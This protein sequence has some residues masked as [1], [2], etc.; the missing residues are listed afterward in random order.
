MLA[1]AR[2]ALPRP[3]LV[4]ARRADEGRDARRGRARRARG[5]RAAPRARRRASSP[6]TTTATSSSA[7]ASP[8]RD[9][10]VV[11]E[12]GQRARP[13][14]R[15]L[16]LHARASGAGSAS[17]PASRSTRCAASRGDEHR[18]RR[19]RARRSPR[20]ERQRA[21]P[22]LRRRSTRAEA[23]LRYRS[24]AV[25][26]DVEPTRRAASA[27][28]STSRRTA[29]RRGQAAVLYEDDAVV[30]A[31]TIVRI[32]PKPSG[33]RAFESAANDRRRD[34]PDDSARAAFHEVAHLVLGGV[35]ARL[36]PDASRASR[37]CEMALEAVLERRRRARRR[38]RCELGSSDGAI[39]A[40]VGPFA[41]RAPA[42]RA[43]ARRRRARSSL[44]RVLDTVVDGYGS[45]ATGL[46]PADEE[47]RAAGRRV[48]DGRATR[49]CSA[50]TTS[51]ATWR[52][53]EQLIER[54][55]SLVALARAALLVSRR[56]ARRISSRSARSALIKAI[57]R[58][59]VNA[60][61]ADDLRDAEHR[62]RDQRH[63]RDRG[64]SVR[65]RAACRATPAGRG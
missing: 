17:R 24:P 33:P 28:S 56:A 39:V 49:S 55:M 6:A 14:R 2:P 1:A 53:R 58:F 62:R 23:K 29:S 54:Y 34:H 36:E 4:P 7:T 47:R 60:G 35:A 9:G 63:F 57:D 11:D 65:V 41:A 40:R 48:S 12:A 3:A 22:A 18:R 61:G 5:R 64:W 32:L 38:S 19:A 43:R 8:P 31:G 50:A 30:G 51:R 27:S 15:L 25:A 45:T 10:P 13:P 44:R 42:R 20:D 21:R 16:A 37:T 59:D 46:A 26:A 52:A